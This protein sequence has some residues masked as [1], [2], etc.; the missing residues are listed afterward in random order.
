MLNLSVAIRIE[1]IKDAVHICISDK[2]WLDDA[3]EHFSDEH[4]HLF[5]IQHTV[6]VLVVNVPNLLDMLEKYAI[7]RRLDR[8]RL[9][10]LQR[11]LHFSLVRDALHP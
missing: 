10:G 1:L 7:L 9:V 4:T 2:L 5:A 11:L 8:V 3:V 6:A